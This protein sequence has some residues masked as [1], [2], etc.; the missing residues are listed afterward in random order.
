MKS[1]K[2][3]KVGL[4]VVMSAAIVGQTAWA[5]AAATSGGEGTV[6]VSFPDVAGNHWA[7]KYITRLTLLGIIQ[8]DDKGR[9]HPDLSVSRQDAVIMAVRMMGLE[10]EALKNTT[11]YVLPFDVSDYAKPYIVE[12]LNKQLLDLK[13]ET[14]TASSSRQAWGTVSATREW[15]ARLIVRAMGQQSLADQLAL[16]ATP[17]K[18]DKEISSWATGAINAAVSLHIVDGFEDGTF[19]PLGSVTRAQMAAFLS[20]ADVEGTHNG[21]RE[22]VGYVN[23]ISGTKI[24]VTD[25]QGQVQEFKLGND[26]GF[27]TVTDDTVKI[28]GSSIQPHTKVYIIHSGDSA[29]YVEDLNEREAVE[30]TAAGTLENLDLEQMSLT[31]TTE[32][33]SRSYAI[34]PNVA[35]TNKDGSGSSLSD[36]LPNS[37]LEL[38]LKNDLIQQI[39]IKSVPVSKNGE[40]TLLNVDSDG[41]KLTWLDQSTNQTET[42]ALGSPVTITYAGNAIDTDQLN[43]GDAVFYQV[44]N[45]RIVSVI[46][47]KPV[48]DPKSLS[49]Q[50]VLKSLDIDN[51]ILA[52][53]TAG[54]ELSAYQIA[55]NAQVTIDGFASPGLQDLQLGDELKLQLSNGKAVK[56]TVLNRSAKAKTL[57]TIVSYSKDSK[58]LTVQDSSGT[59]TAYRLTDATSIN[60]DYG[61]ITLDTFDSVFT[62]GKKVDI[63]ASGDKIVSIRLATS[64]DGTIQ[65]INVYT[66]ELTLK[67]A[68]NDI[69]TFKVGNL[70]GVSIPGQASASLASLK[71]GDNVRIQLSP[72]QDQVAHI[73]VRRSLEARVVAVDTANRKLTVR[74][75]AGS[76]TTYTLDWNTQITNTAQASVALG[77]VP[78]DGLVVITLFGS[79]VEKVNVLNS[80]MGKVTA[81]D[82]ANGKLTVQAFDGTSQTITLGQNPV[83]VRD[84][85][86][87]AGIAAIKQG[88]RVEVAT[89]SGGKTYV[90]VAVPVRKQFS[91]YDFLSKQIVFKRAT[92]NDQ[93]SYSFFAGAYVHDGNTAIQPNYLLDSDPVMVYLLDGKIIE[94]EKL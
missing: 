44:K 63:T 85:A 7:Q 12:A 77:N 21:S 92:L 84:S 23:E 67:T 87:L 37:G 50:G 59:P 36:L 61:T 35:V 8:G 30:S 25:E 79:S 1:S 24:S 86:V 6:R 33:G 5:D 47:T 46:V 14:D 16:Q 56:I 11:S 69:I 39:T 90:N 57:S 55:D 40:A 9:F 41:G 49:G 38:K 68:A 26:V 28:P 66:N 53:N 76:Q 83:M 62:P 60:Y 43:P 31:L 45:D 70:T 51:K 20:R 54:S 58:I 65:Q 64:Y 89:D 29:Y 15:I 93:A 81:V 13:E 78:A 52:I 71:T 3:W 19:R 74:E 2:V 4:A 27:Y 75:P 48:I 32:N 42:F 17:F 94:L 80:V 73:T 18:D 10:D 22:T 88:D 91:S 82:P 34:S 72:A